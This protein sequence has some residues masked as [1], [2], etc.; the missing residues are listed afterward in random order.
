VRFGLQLVAFGLFIG[1][2]ASFA[3]NRLLATQLWN[4]SPNDPATFAVVIV[5]MITIAVIA[6][7]IPAR[8]AVRIQPM[9][10]LRHD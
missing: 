1:V 5:L 8:R 7:W 10:A 6:C 9:I 3:T 2:A 4:T